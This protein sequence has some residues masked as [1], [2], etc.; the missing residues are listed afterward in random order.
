MGNALDNN[1][2]FFLVNGTERARPIAAS[3]HHL[4]SSEA[5]SL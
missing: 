3:L 5:D 4:F 1:D 2:P